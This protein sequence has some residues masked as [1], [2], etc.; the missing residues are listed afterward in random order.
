[1]NKTKRQKLTASVLTF[2]MLFQIIAGIFA[3][4]NI[5]NLNQPTVANA[6]W[7]NEGGTWQY[8]KSITVD[9]DKVE[10]T[11]QA[12]FP[13]LVSMTDESLKSV[14]NG[15]KVNSESG[16]D[17]A[18]TAQNGS[19]QLDHEIETYTPT[20]GELKAWVKIP[21][22]SHSRD[23]VIYIYY[24][25]SSIIETEENINGVWDDGGANNFKMVQHMNQNP[26]GT[27][28]QM[29]DSTQ[30]GNNGTSRG[31]M[32]SANSVVGQVDGA[33]SFDGVDDYVNAGKNR[34]MVWTLRR[35]LLLRPG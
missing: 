2:V 16:F 32:T 26:G 9:S 21:V 25:N 23:T 3:P 18:F 8:R 24:G 34:G 11:D 4:V 17:I 35:L 29:L 30:Y 27:A 10:N 6:A 1:M 7:F 15:G 19:T 12:Y 5:F 14:S 28:P 20:T 22:L 33:T 31:T 13:M